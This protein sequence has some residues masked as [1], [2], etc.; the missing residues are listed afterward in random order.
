MHRR[1][2]TVGMVGDGINDAP[3]LAQAHVGLAIG[4]G[5]DIAIGTADVIL[6]SG[7]LKGIPREGHPP[8]HRYQ[9]ANHAHRAPESGSGVCLQHYF[10]SSGGRCVG[11]N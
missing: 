9:S 6:S 3:A 8:H 7:R 10:D 5:T 11:P 2:R 4:T 1:W